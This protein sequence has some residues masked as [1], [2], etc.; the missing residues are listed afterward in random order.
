MNR[1]IMKFIMWWCQKQLNALRKK[2]G[3]HINIF[4]IKGTE[5]DYPKCLIFTDAERVRNKIMKI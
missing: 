4:E 1:I 3:N 5:K 2:R